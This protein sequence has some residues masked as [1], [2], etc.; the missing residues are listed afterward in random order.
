MS[1][2]SFATKMRAARAAKGHQDVVSQFEGVLEEALKNINVESTYADYAAHCLLPL[3]KLITAEVCTRLPENANAHTAVYLLEHCLAPQELLSQAISWVK[4]GSKATDVASENGPP[5]GP[6]PQPPAGERPRRQRPMSARLATK[7]LDERNPQEDGRPVMRVSDEGVDGKAGPAV[8]L[9]DGLPATPP[10]S[11]NI[12]VQKKRTVNT[13][14]RADTLGTGCDTDGLTLG[15]DDED[16]VAAAGSTQAAF[17]EVPR[18]PAGE[19]AELLKPLGPFQELTDADLFVLAE[20]AKA[21]EYRAGAAIV[22]HSSVVEELHV[23]VGGSAAVSE[24][25][26]VGSLKR[27]DIFG[28]KRLARRGA[29]TGEEVQASLDSDHG[30]LTVL[31][32]S[33]SDLQVVV[34]MRNRAAGRP[35]RCSSV[36]GFGSRQGSR[37]GSRTLRRA[38]TRKF[39]QAKDYTATDEDRVQI[40]EAL[41]SNKVLG[42]VLS[43]QEAQYDM[44]VEKARLV[45]I[46]EGT[47]VMRQ[48]ERGHALFVVQ[49][50]SLESSEGLNREA[51]KIHAGEIFGELGLLYDAPRAATVTALSDCRLW[52]LERHDFQQVM[53]MTYALKAADYAT[54]LTQVPYLSKQVEEA[55]MDIVAGVLEEFSLLRGQDVCA[56]NDSGTSLFMIW[57][58]ACEVWKGGKVIR[59]LKKGD[60]VGEMQL[61]LGGPALSTVRVASDT[62]VVLS[63]TRANLTIALEAVREVMGSIGQDGSQSM[64]HV[65]KKKVTNSLLQKRVRSAL[66]KHRDPDQVVDLK[67]Y[68]L[69]GG[70]GE[71]SFGSVYLVEDHVTRH[72]A[73]VK[74]ASKEQLLREKVSNMLQNER[75]IM[76]LLDSD[77]I[78]RLHACF[79]DKHH[80][81]MVI[82]A[83]LGGELFDIYDKH[84]LF[85]NLAV[86]R[87]H[88]ACVILALEHMHSLHVIY[89]D[90]KLEN[91]LLDSKGFV[92]LTDFGVAKV[93]IGKS[94][95]MCGTADY[96]APETL[97]QHGHNR[98]VDWWALGVLLFIMCSGRSPFDA[99][100]VPQ[101]YKNIIKGLSKVEF[102]DH[103]PINLIDTIRRLCRNK[104]EE[105]LPMQKD[106][107]SLLK[108][109]PF[110]STIEWAGLALQKVEPAWLPPTKPTF[111]TIR[112]RKLSRPLDLHSEEIDPWNGTIET[113]SSA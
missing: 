25:R 76:M 64:D 67:S 96:F 110:F 98:A 30:P 54:L 17:I 70:L 107:V 79:Q 11:P 13:F 35:R 73:A 57:E 52:E 29:T 42:D 55:H 88:S 20:R 19:I 75:K 112:A 48:G 3:L 102:P 45:D 33:A 62:A 58:G 7:E 106:G 101:I 28:N 109:M 2:C 87:F 80:I 9:P 18:P 21:R 97:K 31:S 37:C 51:K 92:K 22:A 36:V 66:A 44:L 81:Y 40:K 27:G 103:L 43:L 95:T 74:V 93:V 1:S 100:E 46:S 32:L 49:S 5:G 72:R 63:L 91:C 111:D 16:Y 56:E 85:G 59:M 39:T 34:N 113:R 71:G 50:G 105:R 78:V 90:L 94:Y 82:E 84:S 83:V 10:A 12:A 104:P 53:S 108:E 69:V 41:Q 99:P 60:W 77:F 15:D 14:A 38:A 65:A 4:Q 26:Q 89:R 61:E 8:S 6:F 86:A 23:I 24:L 68:S 47:Q